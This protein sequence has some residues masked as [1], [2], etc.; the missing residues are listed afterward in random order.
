MRVKV[1]WHPPL[2]TGG[3]FGGVAVSLHRISFTILMLL[4][5]QKDS[6]GSVT[7]EGRA[8]E[9]EERRKVSL[10]WSLPVP[11]AGPAAFSSCSAGSIP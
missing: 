6:G 5:N 8:E 1:E 10:G 11:H 2:R 4:G 7:R 9:E 3:S